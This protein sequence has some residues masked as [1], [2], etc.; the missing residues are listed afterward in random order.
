MCLHFCA[1]C[2]KRGWF[3]IESR[4]NIIYTCGLLDKLYNLKKLDIK[5]IDNGKSYVGTQTL[6]EGTYLEIGLCDG[7]YHY[8]ILTIEEILMLEMLLSWDAL[9]EEDND[10]DITT[11]TLSDIDWIRNRKIRNKEYIQQAHQD[12]I[13]V[14]KQ[15]N[16]LHLIYG[17]E[18][19][20]KESSPVLDKLIDIDCIY[21]ENDIVGFKYSFGHLGMILKTLNQR[22]SLDMN[23][24]EFSTTE[25]M[26]YQILRYVVSSVYMCRIK[27][28]TFSR[29][30]KCILQA[31][32]YRSNNDILSYYD[33]II[34]SNYLSKYL[35]RYISRLNEVMECLKACNL[36]KE[37][38]IVPD[39]SRRGILTSCGK[40][41]I[42][43]S[44][45]KRKHCIN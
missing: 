23:I 43:V 44:S 6:I 40:V 22:I 39:T 15:L 45:R 26:K 29:T 14:I 34:D 3:I 20:M 36:I 16:E 33:Y 4:R 8:H 13:R 12:Y 10:D 9:L 17:N 31:I 24:F 32:T 2:F 1:R 7:N 5:E 41:I 21:D 11:I 18:K 25:F 27:N 38:N 42:T 37:Y 35:K 19:Q 30:H 28:S